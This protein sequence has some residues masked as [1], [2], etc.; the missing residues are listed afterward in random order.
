VRIVAFTLAF[1]AWGGV[2]LADRIPV[3]V[4]WLGDA[5]TVDQGMRVT[6]D[7]SRALSH[8]AGARTLDSADDR[9]VLVE[10]GAATREAT[11]QARGDELFVKMKCGDA[12]K[13]YEA[14]ERMLLEETPFEV[15][16][17]RLGAVE[18]NLLVCYDQLGRADDATRAAER[19]GWAAG[20]N[21]DVQKL[22]ERHQRSRVWQPAYAPSKVVTEPAGGLVYRNLQPIGA[23]PVEVSGGD[24][25]VD[26]IDVELAGRR[27]VHQALGHDGGEIRVQLPKEDR[28]S[29]MVDRVRAKAPD[30]P[31]AEV[32]QIGKRV[33]AA[34]VLALYPTG[35]KV[36]ARWLDVG[37]AQWAAASI[38]VDASGTPAMERLAGYVAPRVE[39]GEA[40]QL[41]VN[42]PPAT[43][44]K[45]PPPPQQKSKWGAWG[46]WYTWV[47]AGGVLALVAGLLIAQNVGSDSLKVDVS[48]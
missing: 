48:H 36:M 2:A 8:F 1:L 23:A 22:L 39:G 11:T 26:V 5:N 28:L 12:V 15:A 14:A 46:K 9:H 24:P 33:G 7:V 38:K 44:V 35:N 21:E 19:L 29:E 42:A 10:G 34:R 32:S 27:R 30:A 16:Q 47:A 45:V 4:L 37:T 20:S 31:P 43:V 13:E 17:R 3:A 41:A 25:S 18:R 40:A 6:D